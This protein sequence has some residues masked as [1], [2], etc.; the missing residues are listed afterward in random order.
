MVSEK[1]RDELEKKRLGAPKS[2]YKDSRAIE[3]G[4]KV[5]SRLALCMTNNQTQ[6]AD[7]KISRSA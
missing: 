1:K 2:D 7:L 5:G 3:G 6:V 4:V